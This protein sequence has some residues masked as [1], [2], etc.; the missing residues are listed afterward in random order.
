VV[1]S[2]VGVTHRLS[3]SARVVSALDR[4][5]KVKPQAKK[6]LCHGRNRRN[7]DFETR[8]GGAIEERMPEIALAGPLSA[9]VVRGSHPERAKAFPTH[10][11]ILSGYNRPQTL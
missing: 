10:G 3:L 9:L 11:P 2:D 8:L 5:V 7:R 1:R 4:Q 6:R